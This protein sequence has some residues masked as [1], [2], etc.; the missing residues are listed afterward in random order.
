MVEED[1]LIIILV[2][3]IHNM[4]EDM[5]KIGRGNKKVIQMMAFSNLMVVIMVVGL[6]VL[7]EQEVVEQVL[8]P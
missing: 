6:I 5:Q 7:M 1:V 3:M 8:V 2:V 4:G